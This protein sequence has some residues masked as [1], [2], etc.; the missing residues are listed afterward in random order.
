ISPEEIKEMM[1]KYKEKV[2]TQL[3]ILSVVVGYS[4]V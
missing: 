3:G 1:D 2:A 4:A